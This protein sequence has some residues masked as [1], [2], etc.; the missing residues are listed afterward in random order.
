MDEYGLPVKEVRARTH[1]MAVY[2]AL[3]SQISR[4]SRRP[5]PRR[6]V[7]QSVN[8]SEPANDPKYGH[9]NEENQMIGQDPSPFLEV[10]AWK[11]S[12]QEKRK[13]GN[14]AFRMSATN[15]TKL[16]VASCRC[17]MLTQNAHF[18]LH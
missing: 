2:P 9:E 14:S 13:L 18:L 17:L 3:F 11:N 15:W 16:D 1:L 12:I 5:S 8:E 7:I 4:C 6:D 10:F